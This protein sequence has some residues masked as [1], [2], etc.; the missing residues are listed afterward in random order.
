MK[1]LGADQMACNETFE[2][3]LHC[4]LNRELNQEEES[5]LQDHLLSCNACQK[6]YQELVNVDNKL[7][8]LE[9][10]EAPVDLKQNI[11]NDIPKD[12]KVKRFSKIVK[13]HPIIAAAVVFFIMLFTSTLSHYHNNQQL[14]LSKH[15]GV[16]TEGNR[17]IIPEGETIEGDF[18]VQNAEV[19]LQGRI[20]GNL[21]L[22]N[23]KL[24][25]NHDHFNNN[26]SSLS[27]H[28]EGKVVEIDRYFGWVYHKIE[29]EFK[30]F[31]TYVMP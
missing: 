8:Q 4:C 10:V 29:Y 3:E 15:E 1:L 6:H 20:K 18:I 27:H 13:E 25:D 9:M 11:L 5:K 23:S 22:V 31:V 24:V 16:I 28:V 19:I 30:N 21:T 7:T 2:N 26:Y 12:N 17:V 14:S